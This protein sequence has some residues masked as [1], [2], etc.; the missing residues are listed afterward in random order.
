ME[1]SRQSDYDK[2]ACYLILLSLLISNSITVFVKGGYFYG[3]AHRQPAVVAAAVAL[4]AIMIVLAVGISKGKLWAKL[5]FTIFFLNAFIKI[6]N[7]LLINRG[8]N[9]IGMVYFILTYG[10]QLVAMFCYFRYLFI[11]DKMNKEKTLTS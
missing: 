5:I 10:L 9:E 4:V 11:K 1:A 3:P 6:E 7:V 8:R 2:L